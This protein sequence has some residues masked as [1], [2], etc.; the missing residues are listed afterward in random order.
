MVKQR[1]LSFVLA[2]CMAFMLIPTTAFAADETVSTL[3]DL[4][5][6]ITNAT[7]TEENPTVIVISGQI[8]VN[9]TIEIPAG[10]YIKLVGQNSDDGLIRA[11]SFTFASSP[12][13]NSSHLLSVQGGLVLENITIDGNNKSGGSLVFIYGNNAF[14]VMN[15]GTTLENNLNGA[16]NLYSQNSTQGNPCHFIMNGGTICNNS[17]S[18][19][20]VLPL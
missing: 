1:I 9:Q 3:A 19:G 4:Q 14:A 17:A 6:A 8:E 7:G 13:T 11:D 10:K 18:Q 5:T 20:L 2:F 12:V 15:E 16:V